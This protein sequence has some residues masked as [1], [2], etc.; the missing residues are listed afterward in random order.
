MEHN[1]AAEHGHSPLAQFAITPIFKFNFL[2]YDIS[3]TN[4]SLAM[5][6][7][8]LSIICLFSTV[9]R[10]YEGVP[11]SLHIFCEE[12]YLFISRM[13]D[14]NLGK[15]G[16]SFVPFVFT[17]F[18]FV[19]FCNLFG[20]IPYSYTATSQFAITLCLAAVIFAIIIIIGFARQGLHFLKIFLPEGVP[21][22]LTPLIVPIEL[23]AFLA[24]PISLSLRLAA[25]MIAGHIL[26]KVLAGFMV[27][28]P[29]FMKVLPLPLTIVLIGFEVFVA[30]LQ[31]YIFAILTC[32]YLNDA[33]NGH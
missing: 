19:L 6:I 11:S 1:Q 25:N 2:G 21:L 29:I 12:I 13:L 5:V 3:F 30:V 15:E 22:W 16:R 27:T 17:L 10:S 33:V 14:E 20:M 26:L 8:T 31:A 24:R 23:F 9:K 32:V 7:V 28:L 18:L 4:S